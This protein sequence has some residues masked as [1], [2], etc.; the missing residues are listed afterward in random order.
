MK[1]TDKALLYKGLNTMVI[2]LLCSFAG[3][4]LLYV[5]FGNPSK[6]LYWPLML[7]GCGICI[8]AI[9]LG[10]RGLR[11]IGDSMFKQNQS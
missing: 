8:T 5:A 4:S 11:H 7:L 10:F 3:P 1:R 9:V 2:C 6:P